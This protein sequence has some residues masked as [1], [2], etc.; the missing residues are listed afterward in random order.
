MWDK[1]PRK[2]RLEKFDETFPFNKHRS[3][4]ELLTRIQSSLLF[5]IRSNHL[6]LNCYLNRIGAIPSKG[7]DN[8]R[9]ELQE[10]PAETVT[11]FLFE[12]PKY[13]G[14]RQELDTK[15]GRDSRD[16]K[17]I[18]SDLDRTRELLKY[19]GRTGRFKAI[20][21]VARMREP[22]PDT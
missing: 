2:A 18:L 11:H 10:G 19:I 17:A 20:G 6:P 22:P 16:F 7:C 5:Q 9:T 13:N 21:D 8:C 15:L 12:C 4:T 3:F 14:V 1:S